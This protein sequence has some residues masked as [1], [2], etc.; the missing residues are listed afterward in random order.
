MN[1]DLI[2]V[3]GVNEGGNVD[4]FIPKVPLLGLEEVV[5]FYQIHHLAGGVVVLDEHDALVFEEFT[6]V[7]VLL[8]TQVL[9]LA[10]V[11]LLL[12]DV[13]VTNIPVREEIL[14]LEGVEL[15]LVADDL[16]WACLALL[17]DKRGGGALL[18]DADFWHHELDFASQFVHKVE[19]REERNEEFLLLALG[20]FGLEVDVGHL[21][22]DL[23]LVDHDLLAKVALA[24]LVVQ[25]VHD[26][27]WHV[28][29]LHCH[30]L[31]YDF[32]QLHCVC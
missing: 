15:L 6:V 10:H 21:L 24:A 23:V 14:N 1:S 13:V 20:E 18:E 22:D 7:V 32:P 8:L 9:E 29:R 12:P 27:L 30:I 3:L 4:N 25:L 19:L 11:L 17:G 26:L 28:E 5:E 31:V 2:V 16:H